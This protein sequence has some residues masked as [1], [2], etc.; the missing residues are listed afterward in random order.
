MPMNILAYVH[1][2]N[3]Y[4]ST[5]AGRVACQAIEYAIAIYQDLI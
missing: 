4:G 5:S 3:V 2:R 1:L